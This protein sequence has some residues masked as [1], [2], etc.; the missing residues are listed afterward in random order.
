MGGHGFR[1]FSSI[2]PIIFDALTTDISDTK[3]INEPKQKCWCFYIINILKYATC[4][5]GPVMLHKNI[6][7]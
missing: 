6:E 5:I 7:T 2:L 1:K 3:F 4:Q